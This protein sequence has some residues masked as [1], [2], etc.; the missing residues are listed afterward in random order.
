MT[1]RDRVRRRPSTPGAKLGQGFWSRRLGC[2]LIG[3]LQIEVIVGLSGRLMDD[4]ELTYLGVLVR[5]V[6]QVLE[7]IGTLQPLHGNFE[8][9]E[10]G[11]EIAGPDSIRICVSAKSEFAFVIAL[12]AGAP[13]R[14]EVRFRRIVEHDDQPLW[15]NIAG[16]LA[17]DRYSA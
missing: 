1:V 2:S 3:D 9:G 5:I 12:P 16:R 8:R 14:R 13:V 17:V 10:R 11:D 6:V 4:V 15:K 7:Q